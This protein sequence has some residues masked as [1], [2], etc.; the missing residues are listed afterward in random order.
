MGKIVFILGF[1]FAVCACQSSDDALVGNWT[2]PIPG[3]AGN[4]V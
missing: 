2:Q 3:Q 4:R 1:L